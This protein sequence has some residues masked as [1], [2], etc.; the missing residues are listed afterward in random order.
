MMMVIMS[1]ERE[2]RREGEEKGKREREGCCGCIPITE[3]WLLL[4]LLLLLVVGSSLL[5]L[6]GLNDKYYKE[7]APCDRKVKDSSQQPKE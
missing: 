7:R 2:E 6:P 5:L 3:R 1:L 4:L